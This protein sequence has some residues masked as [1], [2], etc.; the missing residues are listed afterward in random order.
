MDYQKSNDIPN[1]SKDHIFGYQ[2]VHF[3]PNFWVI[4][5][6]LSKSKAEGKCFTHLSF[7]W[8]QKQMP[9]LA[10]VKRNG[11][12]NKLTNSYTLYSHVSAAYQWIFELKEKLNSMYKM[13][14]VEVSIIS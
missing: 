12:D 7:Y 9:L 8:L 10:W 11:G 2:L 6:E 5:F 3:T 14:N 13:D 1:N 4:T